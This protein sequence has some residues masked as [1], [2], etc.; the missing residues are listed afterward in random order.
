MDVKLGV[1]AETQSLAVSSSLRES[2][3]VACEELDRGIHAPALES[4]SIPP[5]HFTG[6]MINPASPHKSLLCTTTDTQTNT[7][8]KQATSADATVLA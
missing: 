2:A 7:S 5:F 4:T 1:N 3:C 6:K 8:G